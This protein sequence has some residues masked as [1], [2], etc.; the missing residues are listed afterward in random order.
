MSEKLER[1]GDPPLFGTA[2]SRR[3]MRDDGVDAHVFQVL[4]KQ[5]GGDHAGTRFKRLRR[6]VQFP[7]LY[8]RAIY[9]RL[10]PQLV[11]HLEAHRH[12]PAPTTAASARERLA[13]VQTLMDKILLMLEHSCEFV[14]GE[15]VA[16]FAPRCAA[17]NTKLEVYCVYQYPVAV[18]QTQ[19]TF[20]TWMQHYYCTRHVHYQD[21]LR[22]CHSQLTGHLAELKPLLQSILATRAHHRRQIDAC[23]EE[24]RA[25][26]ADPQIKTIEMRAAEHCFTSSASS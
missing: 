22:T 24:H 18:R 20:L 16:M 7:I 17:A 19:R 5:C 4:K 9:E 21:I 12:A 1:S 11:A 15:K 8:N 26:G 25:L 6:R 23:F 14:R 2:F 3:F 13:P 10:L